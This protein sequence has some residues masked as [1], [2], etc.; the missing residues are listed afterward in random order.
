MV[1]SWWLCSS[2]VRTFLSSNR[3]D[4]GVSREGPMAGEALS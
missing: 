4:V 1:L 2:G 3:G